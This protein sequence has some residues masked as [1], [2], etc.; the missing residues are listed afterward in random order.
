MMLARHVANRAQACLDLVEALG[1]DIQILDVTSQR[2]RSLLGLDKCAGHQLQRGLEA[3]VDRI[4]LADQ[5]LGGAQTLGRSAVLGF[6]EQGQSA[7]AIANQALGAGQ[8]LVL[9]LQRFELVVAQI[10]RVQLVDLI[11]QQVNAAV[12]V[13]V[14]LFDTRDRAPCGFQR[15]GGMHDLGLKFGVLAVRIQQIPLGITAKQ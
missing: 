14:S 9:G 11:T 3:R 12:A 13:A 15:A 4:E 7:L 8:A 5:A 10:Q 2:V 6:V 1:I